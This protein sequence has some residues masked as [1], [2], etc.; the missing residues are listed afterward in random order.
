MPASRSLAQRAQALATGAIAGQIAGSIGQALN[1][2]T[3]EIQV[4][5]ET[6]DAAQITLGQQVGRTST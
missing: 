4:A 2:D 6:G 3:F 1:L 5:P